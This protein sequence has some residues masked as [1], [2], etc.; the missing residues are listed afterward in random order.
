MLPD[1]M[2]FRVGKGRAA[3]A[4]KLVSLGGEYVVYGTT[5]G[6]PPEVRFR[7]CTVDGIAACGE[8]M[9]AVAAAAGPVL[10]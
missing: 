3:V 7:H 9:A 8:A 2:N 4:Q 5:S 6:H 1:R 10:G